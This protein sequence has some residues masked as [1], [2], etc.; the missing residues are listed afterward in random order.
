M[1]WNLHGF[2]FFSLSQFLHHNPWFFACSLLCPSLAV[3][4]PTSQYLPPAWSQ[5]SC[6]TS[7]SLVVNGLVGIII[8]LINFSLTPVVVKHHPCEERKPFP[9]LLSQA[10]L[11]RKLAKLKCGRNWKV[12]ISGRWLGPCFCLAVPVP[13]L[14][15]TWRPFQHRAP[16]VLCQEAQKSPRF[17]FKNILLIPNWC[18]LEMPHKG[19]ETA[20]TLPHSQHLHYWES[21]STTQKSCANCMFQLVLKFSLDLSC[22]H[23][24]NVPNFALS[25][26]LHFLSWGSSVSLKGDPW[27]EAGD[28]CLDA[29]IKPP[30]FAAFADLCS[31]RAHFK[32]V[33]S[34]VQH[35]KWSE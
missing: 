21:F 15:Q 19:A 34:H 8:Y 1:F 23:V 27:H 7:S 18:L 26:E 20:Q 16:C 17:S 35:C 29:C 4:F 11:R 25:R 10:L 33:A 3:S 24:L 2:F 13:C 12:T 14:P 28:Q 32:N 30:T 9:Y 22:E 6:L 5:C 31:L